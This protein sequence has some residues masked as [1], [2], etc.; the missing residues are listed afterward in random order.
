MSARMAA[1]TAV[2]AVVLAACSPGSSGSPSSSGEEPS[3]TASSTPVPTEETSTSTT[4]TSTPT[5]GRDMDVDVLVVPPATDAMP[6]AWQERFVIGYGPGKKL[7]GTSPGGDS[8]TLD[9]GPEFGAP[10]PDGTWWFLDPAKRR[11]AHYDASGGFLDHVKIPQRLLVG[12]RYFQWSLPHVLADGTL[13]ATRLDPDRAWLLRL[14]DGRLDEIPVDGFFAP[15]YDDGVL[16]YGSVG[17]R[18]HA[19]VDPVDGSLQT[20]TS[21]RTPA[22]TP[23]A[24]DVRNKLRIGLPSSDTTVALPIRSSSGAR[25]H[26][27]I[28]VRAGSDDTLDLFL[29][30]AGEDDESLQL[31]GATEVSPAGA[32]AEVEA[33]PNPFSEADSGSPAHLVIAPGS[34]TPMLVYVLADGVHVYERTG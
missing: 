26:V 33:L 3:A 30:G 4:P 34:A 2:A 1:A 28:E 6:A 29:Y 17:P 23:F 5:D 31:V 22:G 25:A 14:R 15:T 19:V 7:M 27:G 8:G 24:I 12:G 20:T 9:I 10:A 32:V 13:V 16:L 21:F 11:I 18:T